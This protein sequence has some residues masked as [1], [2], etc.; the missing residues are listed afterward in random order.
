LLNESIILNS[1]TSFHIWSLYLALD[2][3]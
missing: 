2:F 1:S 3:K